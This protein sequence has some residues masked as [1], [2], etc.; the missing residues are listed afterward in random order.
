[1]GDR[2]LLRRLPG[3]K[4]I[5]E[6]AVRW[7]V[8]CGA[9]GFA[10]GFFGPLIFSPEANQGP[11]LGIFI[12]GPGGAVLGFLLGLLPLEEPTRR[13]LLFPLVLI[14]VGVL[15][16]FGGPKPL[17]LGQVLDGR[18][19]SCESAEPLLPAAIAA[20]NKTVAERGRGHERPDWKTDAP[21]TL[22][23][24]PGVVVTFQAERW[25]TLHEGR[26][27]WNQGK[28]WSTGW[29]NEPQSHRA[30]ARVWGSDCKAV[31]LDQRGLYIDRELQWGD[32]PP[33]HSPGVLSLHLLEPV[34]AADAALLR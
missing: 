30:F 27:S 33:K 20:W 28:R 25:T 32:W 18:V 15:F 7:A 1:V 14:G 24:D 31:P 19:L 6:R 3:V 29:V 26:R 34:S 22:E 9:I 11:L 2:K 23:R 5:F 10:I 8:I 16:Y 21:R 17:Y 4:A 13:L 12:T